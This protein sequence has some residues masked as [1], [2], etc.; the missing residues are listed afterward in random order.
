MPRI[1]QI[2]M[3]VATWEAVLC[4]LTGHSRTISEFILHTTHCFP[5]VG[6]IQALIGFQTQCMT[7]LYLKVVETRSEGIA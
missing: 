2:G 6:T 4:S 7:L 5:F 3:M 1:G